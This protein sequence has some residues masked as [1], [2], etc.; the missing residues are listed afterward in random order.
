MYVSVHTHIHG[1]LGSMR[2]LR[3]RNNFK[4]KGKN[5]VII[6]AGT[7]V[8]N[9]TLQLYFMGKVGDTHSRIT[10]QDRSETVFSQSLVTC[11]FRT[12]SPLYIHCSLF[13]KVL[14][15]YA[16]LSSNPECEN[17]LCYLSNDGVNPLT[18]SKCKKT[19]IIQTDFS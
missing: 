6:F 5:Q 16:Q 18:P 12:V 17:R 2:D 7:K 11:P 3:K 19:K 8:S 14:P 1:A 9:L 15:H 13:L 10:N 4:M